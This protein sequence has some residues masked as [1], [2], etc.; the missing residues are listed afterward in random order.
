MK[1]LASIL[2][3][4]IRALSLL[5]SI[6]MSNDFAC[7]LLS[8]I[9]RVSNI[10]IKNRLKLA[11]F[12]KACTDNKNKSYFSFY[13]VLSWQEQKC[14]FWWRWK[15]Y[16]VCTISADDVGN[17]EVWLRS[18]RNGSIWSGCRS[19]SRT[20]KGLSI[21]AVVFNWKFAIFSNYSKL[22]TQIV[23]GQLP[24]ILIFFVDFAL[25]AATHP[26]LVLHQNSLNLKNLLMRMRE[27]LHRNQG[28]TKRKWNF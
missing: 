11:R 6:S 2:H 27:F 28:C 9:S 10:Y 4:L 7:K 8:P 21:C 13:L 17:I 20:A 15:I 14:L 16:L 3:L 19:W 25:H 12:R 1:L 24:F 23:V 26:I 22:F 18:L 5:E